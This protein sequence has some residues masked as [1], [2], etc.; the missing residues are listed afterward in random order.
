MKMRASLAK[1]FMFGT[2]AL[3]VTATVFLFASHNGKF[4]PRQT[5][6]AKSILAANQAANPTS[7]KVDPKWTEAYGKLPMGFEENKGQTNSDVR[8]LSHGQGYELF[9]TAQEAVL[10]MRRSQVADLSPSKRIVA[11]RN[12]RS[13][14]NKAKASVVRMRLVGA[15]PNPEIA[16]LN[17]LP[18]RTDYFIG[19]NPKDWRTGVPSFARVKYTGI[20]PGVDLVFYGNER[21]LEYDYIV[22]PGADPKSIALDIAGARKLRID[23]QGNLVMN[24][25]DGEVE[26]QKPVVYQEMNGQRREIAASYAL[27]GNHRVNFSVA[28]Y[29]RSKALIL[30][31]VLIYSTY[32]GGSSEDT[33]LSIAV[34]ASGDA[35]V[36]GETFN[37]SFP[38]SAGTIGYDAPPSD[39]GVA[40]DGAAFVSELDPTG[41]T[42]LYFSYLSG[43]GAGEGGEFATGIAWDGTSVYMTGQSFSTNFPTTANGN[44][45][46]PLG[47]NPGGTGFI[48]KLNPAVGG[49]SSLLYSSYVGGTN[50]D[51]GIAI[52]VDSSQNAYITGITYSPGINT[53]GAFGSS[54]LDALNGNAFLTEINTAPSGGAS[55]LYST[56]LGG[57]GV[58]AGTLG[59]GDAG[60][61]IAVSSGNAYI[62]GT[63]SSVDFPTTTQ[64]ANTTAAYQPAP[65][66][67]SNGTANSEGTVFVSEIN[68]TSGAPAQL[69]YSTYLAG[70]GQD[71]GYA[72]ALGP[73][74][75]AYVTGSTTSL[76]FPIT[77]KS[78]PS[79][80]F[81]T[82][83]Y[84]AGVAYVSLLDTTKNGTS[85]LT[86]STYLGGDFGD[87]GLGIKV[88]TPGNAYVAGSTDS[89]SSTVLFPL[90]PGA[91][92]TTSTNSQ[93]NAFV[94]EISPLGNGAAD[95]IYSTL[96][97][98]S[99]N[100]TIPDS[101][102][103]IALDSLNNA[104][105]AGQTA[106]ADFPVYPIP[107]AFQTSLTGSAAAFVAKLTLVPTVTVTPTSIS[108]GTV[109]DGNT[110]VSPTP[111]TITNNTGTVVSYTIT[112]QTGNAG[113]F[114]VA[115]GG[116]CGASLAANATPC[117]VN[118]SFT[119][120][121][122]GAETTNLIVQYSPYGITSSQ[123]VILSGTGTNVALTVAP[124]TITF[125]GQLVTTTSATQP[126]VVTNGSASN[127]AVSLTNSTDFSY[128]VA[129][130]DAA[131]CTLTTVPAYT[132]CTY[133]VAFNP[134]A[135]DTGPLA[136]TFSVTAS[137]STQNATL[138][139]IGWDFSLTPATQTVSVAPGV[140]PNPVPSLTV[141]FLGGFPGPVTLA[142]SGA[143]PH[144]NCSVAGTITVAG[145]TP[146]T[147]TTA[148][149]STAPPSSLR[150]PPISRRQVVLIGFSVL[151]LFTL[152]F[153]RRRR[154]KL[155]LVGAL[156][157]IIGLAACSGSSGTT[158]GTYIL[159]ITGSSGSVNHAA[160]VTLTVT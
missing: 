91:L 54:L 68:T 60:F 82:T 7:A 49:S 85:S 64:T 15:N 25:S 107:G 73:N 50:G 84:V 24:D 47:S 106:S 136:S 19:N 154:A 159:T 132:T 95:L 151:L 77:P 28:D 143:I 102:N 13:G 72:I 37:T 86:Y 65:P 140:V 147:I 74:N 66:T 10:E 45:I 139:G 21:K 29:D 89:V 144:G 61:G 35:Y 90:T 31:P 100:G 78:N 44:I 8:F 110:L 134:A 1:V 133:N 126:V 137:S 128:T 83:G 121:I 32:L 155:G 81:Q 158:A 48:T 120:T 129:A 105:I 42:E 9:L 53:E 67:A 122:N 118:V 127:G 113:D 2:A 160:T 157:M 104:Y 46:S 135:G 138:N 39:P 123:T 131:G 69:V 18:G 117:T 58:N 76:F 55:L 142:C 27:S 17:P 130:G 116:T 146:V 71:F 87:V 56:Y 30:D 93:G 70:E 38:L 111:V 14:K 12:L 114:A 103:G 16:G 112:T 149:S 109:L 40:A 101:A 59:F 141:N 63:T 36:A 145:P 80:A 94:S 88:D 99:G 79:T 75:V 153:A 115:P 124:G 92:Q 125:A 150:F 20:Y 5:S 51:Y 108:F 6:G 62:V 22:A 148:G 98:G 3:C 152:P 4:A 11:L 52:A 41:A 33:A 34:D 97:G 57:S 156:V 43:S 23:A 96:L 26:L 119:P